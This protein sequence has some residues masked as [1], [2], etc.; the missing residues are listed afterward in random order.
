MY[1]F[2]IHIGKGQNLWVYI[3]PIF[4][5]NILSDSDGHFDPFEFV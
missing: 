5:A 2:L 4:N 1:I 3:A